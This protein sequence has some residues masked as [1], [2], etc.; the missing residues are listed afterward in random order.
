M[1]FKGSRVLSFTSDT[2]KKNLVEEVHRQMREEKNRI[3]KTN[4]EAFQK[5]CSTVE[6]NEANCASVRAEVVACLRDRESDWMKNC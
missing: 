5:H 2:A 6:G 4:F 1:N 3:L